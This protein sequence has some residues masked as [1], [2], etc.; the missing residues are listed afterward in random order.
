MV[1][2]VTD[3]RR[4]HVRQT[5]VSLILWTVAASTTTA[6]PMPQRTND[7]DDETR[8]EK[9]QQSLFFPANPAAVAKAG[10]QQLPQLDETTT[11]APPA[12]AAA[13]TA[14]PPVVV[15]SVLPDLPSNSYSTATE[16][17]SFVGAVSGT[18]PTA[19]L[20]GAERYVQG[21]GM[22]TQAIAIGVVSSIVAVGILAF[23]LFWFKRSRSRVME[24]R[25]NS[26]NPKTK[27]PHPEWIGTTSPPKSSTDLSKEDVDRLTKALFG[28]PS[29]KQGSLK[30]APAVT[31]ITPPET[32]QVDRSRVPR[33][34]AR[35]ESTQDLP[36]ADFLLPESAR[37]SSV[38]S[39]ASP[40]PSPTSHSWSRDLRIDT[41]DLAHSDPAPL[42]ASPSSRSHLVASYYTS[43][44]RS[45]SPL[46]FSQSPPSPPHSP[47]FPTITKISN[48]P[49]R[50]QVLTS[51]ALKADTDTLTAARS[52]PLVDHRRA[53]VTTDHSVDMGRLSTLTDTSLSRYLDED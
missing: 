20:A 17:V 43:S 16:G 14:T 21:D 39:S 11:A 40:S 18:A 49:L 48:S 24:R 33:Y 47:A 19:A 4:K 51:S 34:P 36:V 50:K 2:A 41:L 45:P 7:S 25:D 9:R 23:M 29:S 13:S 12:T 27:K 28:L 10:Q 22:G 6:A 46:S 44:A 42:S 30:K 31:H 53:S 35:P 37:L 1:V 15:D 26:S 32:A 52:Q 5:S 8:K 3:S 38:L